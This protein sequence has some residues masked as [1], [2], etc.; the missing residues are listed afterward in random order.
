MK[1][2]TIIL[3]GILILLSNTA[4]AAEEFM[5]PK[6]FSII[7]ND[8]P[9]LETEASQAQQQNTANYAATDISLIDF[10]RNFN[11]GYSK[12]FRLTMATLT[13]FDI[14]PLFYDSSKGQIRAKFKSG[15]EIFILLLPSQEKLTHVRITPADGHYDFSKDLISNI[16]KN[17]DRNL[18]SDI[19]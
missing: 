17:I 7:E 18:Y 11:Y 3:A 6:S 12:T 9:V 16:F 5:L 19:N 10:I 13:Q 4:L 1:I 14:T 15:K 2:Y 8:L